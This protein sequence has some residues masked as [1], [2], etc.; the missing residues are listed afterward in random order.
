MILKCY[1][2]SVSTENPYRF[3][4]T[5]E[6]FLSAL[7]LQFWNANYFSLLQREAFGPSVWGS[8]GFCELSIF[9]KCKLSSFIYLPPCANKCKVLEY[10]YS[11]LHSMEPI[12]CLTKCCRLVLLVVMRNL[13]LVVMRKRCCR[14]KILQSAPTW[15]VIL[16]CMAKSCT[17]YLIYCVF[18]YVY[19]K[20]TTKIK[21]CTRSP[22]FMYQ[23]VN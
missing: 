6:T 9:C 11:I 23:K 5:S 15:V 4:S 16:H 14:L 7:Q 12:L 18:F 2:N 22:W 1:R 17:N 3:S 19:N 10:I 13:C 8:V 20:L 21:L